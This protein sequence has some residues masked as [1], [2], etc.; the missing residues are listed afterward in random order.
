MSTRPQG[1]ALTLQGSGL[2]LGAI[3]DRLDT[4]LGFPP[5]KPFNH[6]LTDQANEFFGRQFEF[7]N[8]FAIAGNIDTFG[9]PDR[10]KH[11]HQIL[12]EV[13]QS[14]GSIEPA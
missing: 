4:L 11:R 8:R 9:R 6:A 2:R 3:D 10:G 5:G 14:S 12:L 1:P 13:Q 7:A